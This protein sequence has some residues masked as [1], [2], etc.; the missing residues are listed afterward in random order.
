MAKHALAW[1]TMFLAAAAYVLMIIYFQS[2]ARFAQDF[3]DGIAL[4]GL[5]YGTIA[6]TVLECGISLAVFAYRMRT[7]PVE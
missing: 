3:N 1:F 7:G 2:P 4:A 5:Y 6:A